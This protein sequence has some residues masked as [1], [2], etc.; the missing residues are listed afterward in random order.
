[1]SVELFKPVDIEGLKVEGNSIKEFQQFLKVQFIEGGKK[2]QVTFDRV[3]KKNRSLSKP[4]GYIQLTSQELVKFAGI[5][6]A[7]AAVLTARKQ[8]KKLHPQIKVTK[9]AIRFFSMQVEEIA[10][11]L[12]PVILTK[13]NGSE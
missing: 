3:H 7:S 9:A 4:A 5:C 13:L 12:Y 10:G 6:L 8:C 11:S 1:M 2:V